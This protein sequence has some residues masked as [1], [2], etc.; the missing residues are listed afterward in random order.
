MQGTMSMWGQGPIKG[1]KTIDQ[2][3]KIN[4]NEN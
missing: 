1:P 2:E 3:W 4:L